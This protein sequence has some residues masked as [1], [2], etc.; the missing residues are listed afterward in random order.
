[1]LLSPLLKIV[2]TLQ[3]AEKG[4]CD[5]FRQRTVSE[6]PW[7]ISP[8]TVGSWFQWAYTAY[9]LCQ[10]FRHYLNTYQALQ[11]MFWITY[12]T[13]YNPHWIKD[14]DYTRT[15]YFLILHLLSRAYSTTDELMP[16]LAIFVWSLSW[17]RHDRSKSMTR[18]LE[19][20][21]A[22]SWNWLNHALKQFNTLNFCAT[23]KWTRGIFRMITYIKFMSRMPSRRP[24]RRN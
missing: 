1:M 4:E 19:L 14:A 2:V 18:Q 11:T 12:Q 13:S 6:W 22:N 16:E 9:A 3:E 23:L 20:G 5:V 15:T 24:H 21:L 7:W 8:L 10:T 17:R